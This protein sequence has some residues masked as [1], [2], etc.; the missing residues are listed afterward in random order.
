MGYREIRY[1]G[2]KEFL[3]RGCNPDVTYVSGIVVVTRSPVT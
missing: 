2:T 1:H 3:M